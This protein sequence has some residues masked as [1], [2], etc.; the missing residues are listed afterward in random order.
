MIADACVAAQQLLER[1]VDRLALVGDCS[2]CEVAIGA[3]PLVPQ[4]RALALWSAPIIGGQRQAAAAAKR[5]ALWRAYLGKLFSRQAWAKLLRG[6]VRWD[7][8]WRAL[9]RGGKGAGEEGAAADATIDWLGRFRAFGGERLFIYGTA[10][11]VAQA[12]LDFYRRLTPPRAFQVH[13][14]RGANHAFYSAAWEREVIEVTLAWLAA[15]L[16]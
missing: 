5:A 6:A 14:V 11:P 9:A 2:G 12:A 1:G 10:D 13:L 8:V 4:V 15:R 16:G 3:A 7:L